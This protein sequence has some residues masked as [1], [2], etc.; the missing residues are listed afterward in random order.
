MSSQWL[1]IGL[2]KENAV[3]GVASIFIDKE[4][5]KVTRVTRSR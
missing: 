3:G 1:V 4:S 2:K 5:G